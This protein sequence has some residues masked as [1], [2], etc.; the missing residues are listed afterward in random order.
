MQGVGLVQKA[1]DWQIE[2]LDTEMSLFPDKRPIKEKRGKCR[3]IEKK[4]QK[5]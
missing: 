4:C 3:N 2:N 5:C 1:A